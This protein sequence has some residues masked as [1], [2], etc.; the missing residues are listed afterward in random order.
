MEKEAGNFLRFRIRKIIYAHFVEQSC[1]NTKQQPPDISVE[2]FS[3][4][5]ALY[6]LV[7]L[8][9]SCLLP[10]LV[11]D[12]TNLIQIVNP[13]NTGETDQRSWI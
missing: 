13:T 4:N 8:F 9:N 10:I 3:S 12:I 1:V 5:S 6:S 11:L 7:L 2:A